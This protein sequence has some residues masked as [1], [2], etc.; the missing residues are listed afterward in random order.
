MMARYTFQVSD[1]SSIGM[2]M[3][4][5]V[6]TATSRAGARRSLEQLWGK[7]PSYQTLVSIE[8]V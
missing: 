8:E 3:T 6:L 7:E 4:K 1:T 2:M 5:V